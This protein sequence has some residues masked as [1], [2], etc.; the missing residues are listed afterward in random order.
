VRR[1]KG[2]AAVER[3][4]RAGLYKRVSLD[5][6]AHG[7]QEE[8]LSPETQ[9]DRSRAY[10]SA[11]GWAVTTVEEDIDQSGYRQHYSHRPGLMRLLAAVER[12][13]LT[14][15]V[16]YK[17]SRLS[18]RLKEFLELCD[19]IEAAGAGT[20]SVT[21]QVDTST[22][23][24]RLIRNIL[25]SFAQFQSEEISEHIFETWV[26][27]AR[28][29]ERPGGQSPFG[30]KNRK[31]LLE[32]DPQ[33]HGHLL[34][35]FQTFQSTGSLRAVWEYLAA[36]AVPPPR[37]Q[38]GGQGWSL[39]TI[40]GILGNPVYVGRLDWAGETYTGKW[41]PL[42]SPDLWEDVQALL[43]AR[44]SGPAGRRDSR[45]LNG[46]LRC[47]LCGRPMWT[48]YTKRS[49]GGQAH[50]RRF[51][52]CCSPGPQRKGCDVPLL[53]GD[54]VDAAVWQT[55][56][57]LIRASGVEALVAGSL[58]Q[59]LR[60]A[61]GEESRRRER[62]VAELERAERKASSLL[63][64]LSDESITREQFRQENRRLSE[65]RAAIQGE[66]KRAPMAT[67]AAEPDP[68][69]LRRAAATALEDASDQDRRQ[70]LA[71]LGVEVVATPARV[72]LSTLGFRISLRPRRVGQ[73][74]HFGEQYHRMGYQGSAL[75]DK[76]AAF[77]HRTCTWADMGQIAGRLGRS[78]A[79]VTRAAEG[80][81]PGKR[82]AGTGAEA[83]S[84]SQ[85]GSV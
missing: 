43:E 7:L 10:C 16:V 36:H 81:E 79:A 14:K 32:P 28:R 23:A 21:E 48:R 60:R 46:F 33:T 6:A 18:R 8:I 20:V 62:L 75:T 51:Y 4:E 73:T 77:L 5:R 2:R 13:E 50:L 64:L 1:P 69:A 84:G 68:G 26:T 59:R 55:V 83:S 70:V 80:L 71:A 12:G 57:A 76:Q 24:G 72:W 52:W 54:E 49:C 25:A 39:N 74:W 15:I 34:G 65:Q 11:Q 53:D 44:K 3:C 82:Q 22:P 42:L 58:Q 66:L 40:R 30:T 45:L 27:K 78:R 35:M 38:G 19:R 56:C 47:G 37:Q 61:G 31:G 85:A 17:F 63:D 67:A 29:G 9:E 41:A